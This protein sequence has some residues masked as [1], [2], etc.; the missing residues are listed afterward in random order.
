VKRN[1]WLQ[2]RADIER[3]IESFENELEIPG[4]IFTR[5]TDLKLVSHGTTVTFATDSSRLGT[6]IRLAVKRVEEITS[7]GQC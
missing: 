5:Y 4:D 7:G 3:L 1:F 6:L 2:Q